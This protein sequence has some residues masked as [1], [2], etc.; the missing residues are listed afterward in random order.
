[1]SEGGVVGGLV[2]GSLGP[3]EPGE[4]PAR[5]VALRRLRALHAERGRLQLRRIEVRVELQARRR[6]AAELEDAVA[7]SVQ[8]PV[9]AAVFERSARAAAALAV[10]AREIEQR[11]YRLEREIGGAQ[12]RAVVAAL[13]TTP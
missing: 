12:V 3:A 10:E 13:R 2:G 8:G 7:L 6:A 1:M 9:E 4:L 5:T 11:L